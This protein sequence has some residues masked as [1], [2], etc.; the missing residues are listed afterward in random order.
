VVLLAWPT[1][2]RHK[3]KRQRFMQ[4]VALKTCLSSL[5]EPLFAAGECRGIISRKT[6]VA[7]TVIDKRTIHLYHKRCLLSDV[8]FGISMKHGNTGEVGR[9]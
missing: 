4:E 5:H 9:R 7:N 1:P 2:E 3:Y 8:V 6:R